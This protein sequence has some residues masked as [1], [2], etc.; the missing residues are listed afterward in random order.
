MF[1]TSVGRGQHWKYECAIKLL[2]KQSDILR[3]FVISCDFL[4]LLV[5]TWEMNFEDSAWTFAFATIVTVAIIGNVLV[6]SIVLGQ[7]HAT[8]I[9]Y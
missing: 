8:Q 1:I 4:L 9:E 6:L 7:S 3:F 5:I 2:F